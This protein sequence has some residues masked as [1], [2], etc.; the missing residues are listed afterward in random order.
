M[1]TPAALRNLDNKV[2]GR[3]G[4]PRDDAAA[5][6]RGDRE[7][8]DG[9]TDVHPSEGTGSSQDE[10]TRSHHT[11]RGRAP[12]PRATRPAGH[13]VR[14]VLDVV[15]RVARLVFLALA[16]VVFLGIVLTFAPTND[17]NPIVSTVLGWAETAAGPFRDVF[18]A[19]E[20]RRELLYN[21]ALATAVYLLAASLV[22]RLPGKR[23][24]AS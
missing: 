17:D 16:L 9:H 1:R 3:R 24:A 23:G 15:W 21:Y 20:S 4:R 13:V 14:E 6:R 7:D 5:P 18:T 22:T 10:V 2:L 12:Q 19:D 11:G 8:H